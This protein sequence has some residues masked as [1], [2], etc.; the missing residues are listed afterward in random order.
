LY[1]NTLRIQPDRP[2]FNQDV[3][4]APTFV[5][6]ASGDQNIKWAVYIFRA[7]QMANSANETTAQFTAFP[8]GVKEFTSL[9]KFNYGP[10]GRVCEYFTARVGFFNPENKIVYFTTPDSKMYE[11]SFQ[12]CDVSVIPTGVPASVAPTAV[13][14]TPKPGL[15]VTDLRI[16]PA[17]QRGVD[18]TFFPTF[19][20]NSGN[21]M[22]FTWR[23]LIYKAD[24]LATSF[25]DTT[26]TLSNF[27][28]NPG[29]VQSLGKWNLPLGGPCEN[30]FARVGWQDA[31]NQTQLFLKP[32][33]AVFVK[34]F[35]VCPP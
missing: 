18:L 23:V 10:T 29:E 26:W 19:T 7:D 25:S 12:V 27:T 31:N 30:Y 11:K 16:Q 9:G 2:A 22:T 1:V 8:V 24:N 4:F 20:N 32:D 28:T 21:M 35:T 13:P 3:T 6:T 34:S 33:G 15:F 14:P 5:N 17:P